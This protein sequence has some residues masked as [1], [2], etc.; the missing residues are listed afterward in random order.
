IGTDAI[1][2]PEITGITSPIHK[3][4]YLV[5]KAEDLPRVVK[6]AFHITSVLYSEPGLPALD[7]QKYPFRTYLSGLT[8]SLFYHLC[9]YTSQ[10]SNPILRWKSDFFF[11]IAAED[12]NL[13]QQRYDKD[14][15]Q[16]SQQG[17]YNNVGGKV[18]ADDYSG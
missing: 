12:G 15:Y 10:K 9:K 14:G 4:N 11:G 1:Q 2:E 5:K 8:C 7:P 3:H 13:L 16:R 6:E 18:S 17:S